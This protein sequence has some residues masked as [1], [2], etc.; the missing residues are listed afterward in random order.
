MEAS[1]DETSR[2]RFLILRDTSSAEVL[3]LELVGLG[4]GLCAGAARG[5][6]CP[7]PL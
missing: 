6:L 2:S 5:G 1:E 4:L 7:N 3:V